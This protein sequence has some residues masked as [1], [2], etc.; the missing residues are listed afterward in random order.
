[1]RY[2]TLLCLVLLLGACANPGRY[3]Q[4]N[5]SAPQYL[6][7]NITEDD[8]QPRHEKH[9]SATLRTYK[10]LGKTYT[11]MPTNKAKHYTAKGQA[12]W[13]GQKFHGHLTANGEVYN[14]YTMSAA[15]K[16]LP[17]PS[18][19]RVTNLDNNKQAIV[20]VN[21]RGP[22]HGH[23]LID[24]SYAAAKK[25]DILKTGVGN[26]QIDVITVD[27]Q[28]QLYIAGEP[29]PSENSS[30]TSAPSNKALFIQVTALQD[31]NKISDLARGLNLL[32]QID[33]HTPTENGIYRLRLG[34]FTDELTAQQLLKQLRQDGY[35]EAFTLYAPH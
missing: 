20:R 33:T 19:V 25:L 11:P 5:D 31:G 23:R 29:A 9:H 16:T 6:P 22:F 26:V 28:G 12:S 32:Y 15:H 27:E 35:S 3:S 8:A 1:M 7:Q 21:D 34:P 10:V 30:P 18:F 4:R 24:L 2:L 13:Y 14:M 17:L